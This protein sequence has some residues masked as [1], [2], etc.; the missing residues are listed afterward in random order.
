VFFYWGKNYEVPIYATSMRPASDSCERCHWP[1]KFSNDKVRS[2]RRFATDEKNTA[3]QTYLVMHT[4]GGSKRVGLGRGIHWHIETPVE[5]L[6]TDPLKQNIPYVRTV[7]ANGKVIEYF[8]TEAKLTPEQAQA[9]AQRG[10]L[11]RMDCIDCHNRATHDFRTPDDAIDQAMGFKQIDPDIP[12]IKSKGLE[13]FLAPHKTISEA[14]Q[15]FDALG[16]FYQTQ[17]ADYAANH[18][19]KIQQAISQLKTLYQESVFPGMEITWD[20]HPD[21]L[22]HRD[23]PGCFRCHDGKHVTDDGMTIR[24]ECNVCHTIP[25]IALPGQSEPLLMLGVPPEPDSHKDTNWMFRH[26]QTL[27]QTC[28]GCHDVKNAGTATNDSFCSN[29][30]CHGVDWKFAGLDAPGLRAKLAPTLPNPTLQPTPAVQAT[31]ATPAAGATSASPTAAPTT[32]SGTVAATATP[33]APTGGGAP[34]AIPHDL[35]GRDN[36]LT[37]HNPDGGIKPAPKDHAGRTN[38]TCQGCHKPATSSSPT[39]APTTAPGTVAATATPGVATDGE[40]PP[41]IPHDLAGRDNCLTCHNPEGGIKPA[42]KD[43]AGRTNDL[44]QGCHKPAR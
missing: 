15:A 14:L 8:D 38:D 35:A 7:D 44:C 4:G 20:T 9:A 21:N 1:E 12:F 19:P 42:P 2:I 17:Y 40:A 43:H 36:C 34:P 29:A 10:E 26:K 3:T 11:K 33:A 22:G 32:A 6:A 5:Y 18:Q 24:L 23:F 30:A 41:A 16:G 27:D 28:A 37:C 39:A 13:V 31:P 25:K